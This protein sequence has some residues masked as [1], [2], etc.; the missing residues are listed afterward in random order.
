MIRR[1]L[2]FIAGL[3]APRPTDQQL[4][5]AGIGY[6]FPHG[7]PISG[8]ECHNGPGGHSGVLLAHG[9]ATGLRFSPSEQIWRPVNKTAW[10]GIPRNSAELPGPDDLFSGR[11]L[12]NKPV[13]LGDGRY[14]QVPIV[15]FLNGHTGLPRFIGLDEKGE[16]CALVKAEYRE[17]YHLA[18]EIFRNELIGGVAGT[19]ACTPAEL[20]RMA[21]LSLGVNYRVSEIEIA[22]LQLLDTVNAT[23]IASVI[24]DGDNLAQLMDELRKKKAADPEP[25]PGSKTGDAV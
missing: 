17:L 14:W 12:D 22:T 2:Y 19:G 10:V 7:S 18:D 5:E 25:L 13:L 3:S 11:C 9:P 1:F 15:R 24:M 23:Q 21:A 8:A 4:A 20:L 6:A 16:A